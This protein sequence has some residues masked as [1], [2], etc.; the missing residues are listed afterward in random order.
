MK[1][2]AMTAGGR[3]VRAKLVRAVEKPPAWLQGLS[4]G[5]RRALRDLLRRAADAAA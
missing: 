2:I 1:L 5:D 3:R 4:E